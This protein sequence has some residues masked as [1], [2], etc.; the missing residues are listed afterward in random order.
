MAR[1]DL[2]VG[3]YE[4]GNLPKKWFPKDRV[5]RVDKL[6]QSGVRNVDQQMKVKVTPI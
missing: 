5:R 3:V 2:K 6:C 4:H 1:S